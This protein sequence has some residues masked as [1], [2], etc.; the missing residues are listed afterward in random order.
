MVP[1]YGLSISF[2][3]FYLLKLRMNKI[4]IEYW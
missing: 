3:Y 2:L 4:Q 1:H